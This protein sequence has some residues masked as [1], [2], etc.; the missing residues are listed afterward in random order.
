MAIVG[1]V[2]SA[3]IVLAA[4]LRWALQAPALLPALHMKLCS[5]WALLKT[6]CNNRKVPHH[7]QTTEGLKMK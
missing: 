3:Q 4:L 5:D 6:G 7:H 1:K 2:P